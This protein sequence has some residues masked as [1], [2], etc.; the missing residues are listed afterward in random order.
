MTADAVQ[1]PG[2]SGLM[3]P[4]LLRRGLPPNP[5]AGDRMVSSGVF[6]QSQHRHPPG[7]FGLDPD[8]AEE[9]NFPPG[10]AL[11]GIAG[12]VATETES[13]HIIPQEMGPFGAVRGMTGTTARKGDDTVFNLSLSGPDFRMTLEADP[14]APVSKQMRIGRGMGCMAC[15]A[16]HHVDGGVKEGRVFRRLDHIVMASQTG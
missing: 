5:M 3:A 15:E 2:E 8:T 16:A 14:P 7:G 1:F 10:G 9:E 11:R 13:I 4:Q 12:V 6:T